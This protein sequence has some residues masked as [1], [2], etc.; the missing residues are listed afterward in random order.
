MSIHPHPSCRYTTGVFKMKCLFTYVPV[1]VTELEPNSIRLKWDRSRDSGG[2]EHTNNNNF[3]WSFQ[4]HLKQIGK[5][6]VAK[7]HYAQNCPKTCAA[8][9]QAKQIL[10]AT[11]TKTHLITHI[12]TNS[13]IHTHWHTHS[14]AHAR[15][16]GARVATDT[17]QLRWTRNMKH[18]RI[19]H[20]KHRTGECVL[21][22]H[23]S[24]WV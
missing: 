2:Q 1:S 10:M 22:C 23:F 16:D 9:S 6:P 17:Q 14:H 5:I 15:T 18:P 21:A 19:V 20:T 12:Q 8:R 24:L 3:H 13:P 7:K 11:T 4:T